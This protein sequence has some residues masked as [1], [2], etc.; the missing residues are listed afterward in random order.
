ME[1]LPE[2]LAAYARM[3]AETATGQTQS[4]HLGG[5]G[6]TLSQQ[7]RALGISLLLR[8]A[9]TDAFFHWLIQSA[10]VR[11]HVLERCRAEGNEASPHRRASLNGP[12]FDAVTASQWKLAR[13]IAD[14]SADTWM[15][16]EEYE[17]DFAYARFL[18]LL[19][20]FGASDRTPLTRVLTQF[21]TALEGGSA[22]RLDLCL[23]LLNKDSDAFDSAFSAVLLDHS[24]LQKK[25][26]QTSLAR[27]LAFEPNSQ[28][29]VEGLA[30]LNIAS[31]LGL[32]T[33]PEY[34][35]CPGLV[36]RVTYAPFIP[37]AFPLTHPED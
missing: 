20:H 24:L 25:Q 23:A 32:R 27:D 10:L 17:D 37:L 7:Y 4:R 36:R 5:I 18:Y 30:V 12:F 11:A 28:V 6:H 15:Q 31:A 9:N 2:Q 34:P 22:S 33:Q 29:M 8:E 16:G 35:L 13:K 1:S 3:L 14:H 26:R 19:V 21:E